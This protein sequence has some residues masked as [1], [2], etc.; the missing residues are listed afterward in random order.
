MAARTTFTSAIT[1]GI[2]TAT[3]GT[4]PGTDNH[5]KLIAE[6]DPALAS[7]IEDLAATPSKATPGKTLLDETLVV[8]MGEF[9]RTPGPLNHMAGRDHHK[10]AFPGH[11]L[12]A[13]A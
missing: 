2:T 11:V 4:A 10:H 5:Y 3:S 9:G 13:R 8:C 12:P 6:F 7:L 1:A